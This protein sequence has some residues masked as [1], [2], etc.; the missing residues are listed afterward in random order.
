VK[1]TTLSLSAG[2][3]AVTLAGCGSG[4]AGGSGAGTAARVGKTIITTTEL[5]ELVARALEDPEFKN[6]LPD[7]AAFQRQVLTRLVMRHLNDEAAARLK[8]SVTQAEIDARY[9]EFADQAQ[10]EANLQKQAAQNGIAKTDIKTVVRDFVL[11]EK[12]GAKVIASKPVTDAVVAAEYKKNEAS[13]D[14]VRLQHILVK[15]EKLANDILTQLRGGADF[16]ALAKR[17]S[18]DPGS[19]DAGGIYDFAPRGQYVKPFEDAAFST[20]A[21]QLVPQPV[22][23]DFG[24]HVMKVLGRKKVTLAEAAPE[25]KQRLTAQGQEK[26]LPDYLRELTDELGISVNPRFGRWD[27]EAQ[28]VVAVDDELSSPA[29][30]EGEQPDSV[31]VEEP[32]AGEQLPDQSGQ[33]PPAEQPAPSA[34]H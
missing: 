34:S 14:Q 1:R 31:D 15:E 30:A 26:A 25:I 24:F 27:D 21:G 28:E 9:R 22:K 6:N 17:Y 10:G 20:P 29:P 5:T 33:Q 8:V 18:T 3:L 7:Q 12:L 19:K 2:L 16:A 4:I 32:P 23:T 13:Y 11:T